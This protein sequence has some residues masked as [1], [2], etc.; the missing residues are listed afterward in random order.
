MF[1]AYFD[2]PR[3]KLLEMFAFAIAQNHVYTGDGTAKETASTNAKTIINRATALVDAVQKQKEKIREEEKAKEAAEQKEREEKAKIERLE[4]EKKFAE[5]EAERKAKIERLERAKKSAEE[6]AAE[7]K[8]R[9][10]KDK[11]ALAEKLKTFNT[12]AKR[13]S[14]RQ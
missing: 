11:A 13:K 7:R 4:R 3:G 5:E 9:E 2:T 10:E 14:R 8:K 12:K 6:E 1:E